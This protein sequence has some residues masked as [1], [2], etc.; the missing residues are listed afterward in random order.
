[1]TIHESPFF[2]CCFT[3]SQQILR[4]SSS[5]AIPWPPLPMLLDFCRYIP[6]DVVWRQYQNVSDICICNAQNSVYLH[7]RPAQPQPTKDVF[8]APDR[9]ECAGTCIR[10]RICTSSRGAPMES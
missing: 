9:C 3:S 7:T 6:G 1:M 5:G 8:T 4:M 2:W 10:D